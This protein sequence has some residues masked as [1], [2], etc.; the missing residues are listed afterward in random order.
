MDAPAARREVHVLGLEIAVHDAPRVRGRDRVD[1][2]QQHARDL[3]GRQV[4]GGG[5]ALREGLSLEEVHHHR[6]RAVLELQHVVHGD[7]P[8][9]GERARDLGLAEEAAHRGDVARLEQLEGDALAGDE[10]LGGPH[11][12][13]AT[14]AELAHEA[15]AITDREALAERRRHGGHRAEV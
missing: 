9:V 1:D 7:D 5:D 15:V 11:H 6:R 13:H 3:V 8:R 12:A 10:V 14:L 2:G 4:T